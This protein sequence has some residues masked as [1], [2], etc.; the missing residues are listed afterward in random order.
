MFFIRWNKDVEYGIQNGL[1]NLTSISTD[2]EPFSHLPATPDGFAPNS[3]NTSFC[4][5][6]YPSCAI[7]KQDVI[8]YLGILE[9]LFH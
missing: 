8:F 6:L 5:L 4:G 2:Y 7:N 9:I 1:C 3:G